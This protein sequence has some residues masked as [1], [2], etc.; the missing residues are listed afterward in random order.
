MDR[1]LRAK[2]VRRGKVWKRQ[3]L[4]KWK[5]LAE[6]YQKARSTTYESEVLEKFE[7]IYETRNDVGENEGVSK[8][9]FLQ[10]KKR[11]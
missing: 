7:V 6:P 5:G 1:T 4:V 8:A 9:I 11:D 10:E 3:V 2:R